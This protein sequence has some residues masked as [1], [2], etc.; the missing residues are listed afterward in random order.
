MK[1]TLL[2]LYVIFM[3]VLSLFYF[4]QPSWRFTHAEWDVEDLA[5]AAE[6][7]QKETGVCPS[8]TNWFMEFSGK[9][10]LTDFFFYEGEATDPWKHEYV[11]LT[12]NGIPRVYSMG[13][14]GMSSSLGEDTDDINSWSTSR[15][16]RWHYLR[17]WNT[18]FAILAVLGTIV[19]VVL[20]RTTGKKLEQSP[21]G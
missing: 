14:D 7:Y 2:F 16:W 21:G 3:L 6:A 13:Y 12:N 4:N 19:F 15:G 17:G 1:I 8:S 20:W 5:K 18:R 10:D 9:G 11:L